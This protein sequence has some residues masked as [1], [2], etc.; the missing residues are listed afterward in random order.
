MS[1]I[2][3]AEIRTSDPLGQSLV[4]QSRSTQLHR[5]K[6]MD[7]Q[8]PDRPED[9]TR[10]MICVVH[11][12]RTESVAIALPSGDQALSVSSWA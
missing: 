10:R 2:F 1:G 5:K 8:A 4:L 12:L 9:C 6:A 11:Y 3:R 7:G